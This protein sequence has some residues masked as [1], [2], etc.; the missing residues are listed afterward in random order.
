MTGETQELVERY[1]QT[2]NA[3]D[4]EAFGK[5]LHADVV[6]EIPQTRERVRGRAGFVDFYQ[7]YPGDWT[8]ELARLVA[9]QNQAVSLTAFRAN[10]QEQ[11]EITIFEFKDGLISRIIDYWP[12][13]YEPPKRA[14]KF[15]E[16]Y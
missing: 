9:D 3:R 4:W 10:G 1:W 6:Y 13:P 7:T 5:T 11:T 2:T 8:L 12:E 15:V 16:R 14:S